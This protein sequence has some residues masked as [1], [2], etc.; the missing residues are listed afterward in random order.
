MNLNPYHKGAVLGGFY[1]LGAIL[2]GGQILK[3]MLAGVVVYLSYTLMHMV[4]KHGLEPLKENN[5][6]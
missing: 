1:G 5:D 6:G 4:G 2:V 3:S